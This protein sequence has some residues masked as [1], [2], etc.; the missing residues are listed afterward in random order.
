ML[1]SLSDS[2]LAQLTHTGARKAEHRMFICFFFY[3][4]ICRPLFLPY[5]GRHVEARRGREKERAARSGTASKYIFHNNVWAA[6]SCA[7]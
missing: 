5:K 6:L 4:L 2:D 1:L 7:G 3:V